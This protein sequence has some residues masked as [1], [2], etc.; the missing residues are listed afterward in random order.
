MPYNEQ[1]ANRV[2]PLMRRRKG[3]EEKKMFGG[4]GFLLNGNMCCGA[5]KEFLVLRVG[6]EIYEDALSQRHAKEFDIT[7]R[8]MTGWVMIEPAGF[9]S[10]DDLKGWVSLVVEFTRSLP[11]K[12]K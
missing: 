5:W 12:E 11:T 2:R 6:R 3:F 1:T 4:V 10:V 8:S 7:G 9:E